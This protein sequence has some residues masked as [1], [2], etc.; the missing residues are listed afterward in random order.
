MPLTK[1][2]RERLFR[3]QVCNMYY[4]QAMSAV[5]IAAHYGKTESQIE[6]IL[7]RMRRQYALEQE[8]LVRRAKA[9]QAEQAIEISRKCLRLYEETHDP[10]H[11][12]AMVK[13]YESLRGPVSG[14][15]KSSQITNVSVASS[16]Q[17]EAKTIIEIKE[18]EDWYGEH[19]AR[20][21]AVE[22]GHTEFAKAVAAH[23][24]RLVE[25]REIQGDPVRTPLGEDGDVHADDPE[26]A[27]ADAGVLAGG[28]VEAERELPVDGDDA[29]T[30]QAV[31]MGLDHEGNP[32]YM[33][34][35][36]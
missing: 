31:Y 32:V 3:Q 6:Y 28:P 36:Q 14:V 29:Q 9:V 11:L 10:E 27:R 35:T 18:V 15:E 5:E 26:G 8:E 25:T 13:V 23:Q 19:S 12:A 24:R 16:S 20:A 33:R 22:S 2:Q 1:T 30:G 21:H 4:S 7:Y 17:A 34:Q